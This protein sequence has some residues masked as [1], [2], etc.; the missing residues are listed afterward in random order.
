MSVS[1]PTKL[2]LAFRSGDLC[3]F[4]GC[5]RRLTVD[6]GQESQPAV[7]GQAAHI[8][9]EKPGAARYNESMTDQ[10]RNHCDNLI[11]LCCDHHT[12]IDKQVNDFSVEA[13]L[14]MKAKHEQ[15][16]REAT[17]D[18][19]AEVG[20][21][22]LE[23]AT[24]WIHHVEATDKTCNFT[25]IPLTDKIKKNELTDRATATI[26]MGLAV[27]PDV[28]AFIVSEAQ[29]DPEFPE[30]LKAGFLE[31]Y[32]RIR[33][34][35]IRG[36]DLFDLMCQFAQRGFKEQNQRSAGLAILIYF[37]ESCEVFAK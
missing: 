20:F 9:G 7:I 10:Q 3:A 30:R 16:I 23:Q 27:M 15:C 14:D 29:N 24:Q 2:I 34:E 28:K 17:N 22:E 32:Y 5:N 6:G 31:E 12:Q 4:P 35:G 18:A 8:A 19:F 26:K 25:V 21:P 36:D 37:F 11:Y 1:Y 33:K 13:L